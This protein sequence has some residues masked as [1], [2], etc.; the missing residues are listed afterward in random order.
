M[1]RASYCIGPILEKAILVKIQREGLRKASNDSPIEW[2]KRQYCLRSRHV[3][4]SRRIPVRKQ[5]GQFCT[6]ILKTGVFLNLYRDALFFILRS[7]KMDKSNDLFDE[8]NVIFEY[9]REE[10]IDDGFLVPVGRI[11]NQSGVAR[12]GLRG[13]SDPG[14][15]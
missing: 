15:S 4:Q 12:C 10:A 9:T 11:G 2:F 3:R 8:T 13:M 1:S 6:T 7:P 14:T 5:V